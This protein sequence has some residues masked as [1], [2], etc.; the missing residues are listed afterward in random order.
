[1]VR[2]TKK[3]TLDGLIG[4]DEEVEE[5]SV[6]YVDTSDE[7]LG[8][9]TA[10][11]S[12]F[13]DGNPKD[14]PDVCFFGTDNCRKVFQLKGD[15][16]DGLQ[17][18]CGGMTGACSRA[19]HTE[20]DR[21]VGPTGLYDVI[22]TARKVDGILDTHRTRE[23]AAAINAEAKSVRDSHLSILKKSPGYQRS[24]KLV[25]QEIRGPTRDDD[26][27][28]SLED[29]EDLEGGNR[30]QEAPTAAQD[31][32]K[33]KARDT[34]R[35][36]PP[37]KNSGNTGDRR[38]ASSDTAA[39]SNRTERT[40][41][42]PPNKTNA[43][44]STTQAMLDIIRS[45]TEK[46]DALEQR[47]AGEGTT[48]HETPRDS[49]WEG[50]DGD[51]TGG[52]DDGD[53]KQWA[54]RGPTD[55]PR[56]TPSRK[57]TDRGGDRTPVEP[58]RKKFYGVARGRTPGVYATWPE[59]RRQV[60]G[61][62]NSMHQSFKSKAKA[63]KYVEENRTPPAADGS[64]DEGS[65]DSDTPS[66]SGSE[67]PPIRSKARSAVS[68]PSTE[69]MTPDPSMGKP[70]E[71]FNMTVADEKTMIRAMSPPGVTD[72]S[73]RKLLA[74]ATLDAVQL[75]GRC[76]TTT[77]DG[78]SSVA[79]AIAELAEDKRGEW[80]G[81]GLRRDV[82]WKAANRTSLKTITSREVLQERH[83]E[84]QGLKGD[85]Y[86]NQ[87]NAYR[88]ILSDLHWSEE[89]IVAWAQLNWYQRLGNDTLDYYLNL[90]LHLIELS[91]KQ[92]WEYA[93][94]SLAHHTSKLA[95]I[96]A[97]AP[98]RLCCLVRVYIYLRDANRQSFYSEKLQEKRNREVMDEISTL[99]ALNGAGAG[100]ASSLCKK[101]GTGLHSGGMKNCPFKNLTDAE[102]RT[103]M[104]LL[105]E[106]LG[107]MS[108]TDWAKLLDSGE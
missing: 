104:K 32:R 45:L 9:E 8:D 86:E 83:S 73:T 98:S 50:S 28:A 37:P 36:L 90:H 85:V 57:G 81:D 88:A 65:R 20:S 33:E 101:C 102:A 87:T 4:P 2:M 42:A 27:F 5:G 29:W 19:G 103:K 67:T 106:Q 49:G 6:D 51:D 54:S 80:A 39:R 40:T 23:A 21:A 89:A 93:T 22:R 34:P 60:D 63:R 43:P 59:A 79:E 12:D 78:P 7:S 3:V 35:R 18:V 41:L 75:P 76:S 52:T 10:N 53:L 13:E 91:L 25:D 66:S 70:T 72:S 48:R 68:H 74:G 44:D 69:Y 16:K 14:A 108:K 24:L 17:R 11:V 107:K 64:D 61:F 31:P 56:G 77:E 71:Y 38:R 26:T 47:T 46:V 92:G 100:G 94:I 1:M 30:V 99:K 97:Q 55:K 95:N 15:S 62:R 82:Q 105:F 96:R 58:K 84:L